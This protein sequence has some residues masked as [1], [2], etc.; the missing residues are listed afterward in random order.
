MVTAKVLSMS[1]RSVCTSLC[2][3][4]AVF[5]VN[6][7]FGWG[8]GH[9]AVAQLYGQYM[10]SEVK[11]FLGEWQGRLDWWCHYPDMTGFGWGNRRYMKEE[12]LRREI[13]DHADAF[14]KWGFRHAEWFHRHRGRAVLFFMLREAFR[15]N[16]A[17]LAA[18][19]LSVISHSV[20]DR[21][22]GWITARSASAWEAGGDLPSGFRN[23]FSSRSSSRRRKRSIGR[24]CDLIPLVR[25]SA[26]QR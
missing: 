1:R 5:G 22:S 11:Q 15:A 7:A 8:G 4:A 16:D 18:F 14:V 19:C 23:T 25:V 13:G 26:A 24:T 17:K 20:S 2:L 10:P 9:D 12:D 21:S 6:S 3:L